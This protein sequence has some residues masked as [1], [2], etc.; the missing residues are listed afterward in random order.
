[1]ATCGCAICKQWP[2]VEARAKRETGR[3]A[4][5]LIAKFVGDAYCGRGAVK[6]LA[7]T[8]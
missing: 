3:T 6:T 2:L 1:M 5:A 8:P 7:P 4:Q